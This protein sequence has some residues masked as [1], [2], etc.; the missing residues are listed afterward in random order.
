MACSSF[1]LGRFA[2]RLAPAQPNPKTALKTLKALSANKLLVSPD[3]TQRTI[4]AG[5]KTQGANDE[6]AGEWG[7]VMEQEY[8]TF[9]LFELPI[10]VT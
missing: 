3:K 1:L 7:A 5:K 8:C 4:G 2:D 10:V 9:V 6:I